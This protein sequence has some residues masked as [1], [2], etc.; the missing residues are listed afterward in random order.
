MNETSQSLFNTVP[1]MDP[2]GLFPRG[3]GNRTVDGRKVV[4]F[5]DYKKE[6]VSIAT[7]VPVSSVRF[8][9]R[10]PVELKQRFQEWAIAISLVGSFFGDKRKTILWFQT[11]NPLLGNVTPRAM[12]RLGRFSKLLRFIRTA[13]DENAR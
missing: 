5:L 7:G 12:I 11:E 2:F 13:L 9:G 1:R 10:M 6:D 4:D 3:R 8:D